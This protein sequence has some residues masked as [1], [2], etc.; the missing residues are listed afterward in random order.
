[1][2]MS[3]TKLTTDEKTAYMEY[4]LA[5]IKFVK[6]L[7]PDI[8]YQ[9]YFSEGKEKLFFSSKDVNSTYQKYEFIGSNRYSIGIK[10]YSEL[11]FDYNGNKE[12]IRI[13]SLPGSCRLAYQRWDYYTKKSII[14]FSRLTFNMKKNNFKEDFMKDC[15]SRIVEYI[16]AN[17]GMEIDTK[18]LN[19]RLK[20]LLAFS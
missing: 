15:Q 8:S 20:K 14:R 7:Y 2:C 6:S 3:K 5:K 1:M 11:E 10:V 4:N 17:P 19:P 9:S 12:T 16:K 18:H 13:E